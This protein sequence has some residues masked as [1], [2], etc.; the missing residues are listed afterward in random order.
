MD[1][2]HL[3]GAGTPGCASVTAA[4]RDPPAQV[5][6][7]SVLLLGREQPGRQYSHGN[8]DTAFVFQD[9]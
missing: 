4:W 6:M 8:T 5:S 7:E 2:A 9:A 1:P 3:A